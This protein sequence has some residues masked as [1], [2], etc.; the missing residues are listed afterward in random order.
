MN[1]THTFCNT[2]LNKTTNYSF[3][4]FFDNPCQMLMFVVAN[5]ILAFQL[6]P[7]CRRKAHMIWPDSCKTCYKQG[8]VSSESIQGVLWENWLLGLIVHE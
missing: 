7:Q 4:M 6:D 2:P 5:Y 3:P 8:V 1:Y